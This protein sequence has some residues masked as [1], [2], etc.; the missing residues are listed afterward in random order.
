M[1]VRLS[2]TLP[3]GQPWHVL[4]P[5]PGTEGRE[6]GDDVS[7]VTGADIVCG[8]KG[9]EG[10]VLA[11]LS[12]TM[13]EADSAASLART[14]VEASHVIS[15]V[16]RVGLDTHLGAATRW[17]FEHAVEMDARVVAHRAVLVVWQVAST[18]THLLVR[19]DAAVP[20]PA[21]IVDE[22]FPLFVTAL[23]VDVGDA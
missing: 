18:N 16:H 11:G 20:T 1:N 2:V 8:L 5:T 6:I 17:S 23:T 4:F 19:T 14:L 7:R 9:T 21:D 12:V 13:R 10:Q 22:L 15:D 3:A